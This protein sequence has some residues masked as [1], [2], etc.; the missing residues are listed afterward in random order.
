MVQ[1]MSVLTLTAHIH[2]G[3]I[4]LMSAFTYVKRIY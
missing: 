4:Y 1:L 2:L 3:D